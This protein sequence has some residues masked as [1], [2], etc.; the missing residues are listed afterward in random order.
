MLKVSIVNIPT[1]VATYYVA[2]LI[3]ILTLSILVHYFMFA[4][5]CR[6]LYFCGSPTKPI[7]I[8]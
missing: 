8:S 3:D 7:Q 1:H 5:S 6:D 4:G 2:I